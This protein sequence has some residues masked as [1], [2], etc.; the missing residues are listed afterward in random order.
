MYTTAYEGCLFAQ[1]TAVYVQSNMS[2]KKDIMAI[3][4]PA[5]LLESRK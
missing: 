2:K 4:E 3:G 5:V 1:S